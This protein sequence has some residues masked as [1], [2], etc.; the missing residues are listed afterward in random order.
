MCVCICLC[1]YLCV[2]VSHRIVAEYDKKGEV[3]ARLKLPYNAPKPTVEVKRGPAG[4]A[5]AK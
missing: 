1:L 2:C 3:S 5:P 4:T